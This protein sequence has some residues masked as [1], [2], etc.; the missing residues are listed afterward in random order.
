MSTRTHLPIYLLVLIS[1]AGAGYAVGRFTAEPVVEVIPER[2]ESA[3]KVATTSANP[4]LAKALSEVDALRNE[5][6]K[7]RRQLDTPA[8]ESSEAPV[9]IAEDEDAPRPNSWRARMEELKETD[10][11]RYQKEMERRQQFASAMKQ[12]SEDRDNFLNSIDTSLLSPEAQ[13]NHYRFTRAMAMQA[14]L[15]EQIMSFRMEGHD[16][17]ETLQEA[18]GEVFREIVETREL[19]REALLGAIAT[20]MGLAGDDAA[21][22][23]TLVNEVFN[24]TGAQGPGMPPGGRGGRGGPMGRGGQP[25]MP[26]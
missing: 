10:P 17:P 1:V 26:R 7:L 8:V 9:E 20:S 24:A 13:E 22:F 21:D 15:Q 23:T 18:M 5:N 25:Q 6:K 2:T 3:V 16:V 14:D 4:D 19:E 11:E 12:M